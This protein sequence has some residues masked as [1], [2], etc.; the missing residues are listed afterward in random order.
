MKKLFVL[1]LA[2]L[3]IV[4]SA[5]AAKTN[6]EGDAVIDDD[7]TGF[8][9]TAWSDPFDDTTADRLI[10][11]HVGEEASLPLPDPITNQAMID[12]ADNA[13]HWAE[14]NRG[15][16]DFVIAKKNGEDF[17]RFCYDGTTANPEDTQ[18]EYY[19]DYT[20]HYYPGATEG[21]VSRLYAVKDDRVTAYIKF[22]CD[23][24]GVHKALRVDWIPDGE[25][26]Q[27]GSWHV[28]SFY[29][30]NAQD[31]TEMM[32]CA[33]FGYYDYV[34]GVEVTTQASNLNVRDCP[35]GEIIGSLRKG[36][37]ITIY[38][39]EETADSGIPYTLISK[40][41][42]PDANGSRSLEYFGWVATE[43]ITE[44]PDW[45]WVYGD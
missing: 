7:V 41:S 39:C 23:N 27:T 14:E 16:G 35:D 42:K 4:P 40:W 33:R 20:S 15:F 10:I 19:Y 9:I 17:L 31:Y 12:Y 28:S 2:L 36:A 45:V 32:V 26:S 8:V 24:A 3:L 44:S 18:D 22:Y 38:R 21:Q 25:G 6:Y 34:G 5:L 13:W 29:R 11:A 30:D 43:Y 1:L 37:N